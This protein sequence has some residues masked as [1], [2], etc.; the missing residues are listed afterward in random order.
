MDN[1]HVKGAN[2][3]A[4][5][6]YDGTTITAGVGT[7]LSIVGVN[8]TAV[9]GPNLTNATDIGVANVGTNVT[10]SIQNNAVTDA[11]FRQ[12]A[13]Y[14]VV[15]KSTT[16]TG[17]VA[18]IGP[19]S[20]DSV[21]G[22]VGAG[23][24]G[25]SK[26]TTNQISS[27][28]ATAGMV[29]GFDGSVV[30]WT[31]LPAAGTSF[32]VGST[33][34]SNPSFSGTTPAA[35]T[36]GKNIGFQTSGT[37]VSAAL[38]GDGNAAHYFDG[39]GG[40]STPAGGSAVAVNGV[41]PSSPQNI[42]NTARM[43]WGVTGTNILSY[44][45]NLTDAEIASSG[46]TTRSKLPT[47]IAYEDEN[48]VFSLSNHFNGPIKLTGAQNWGWTDLGSSTNVTGAT[49]SLFKLL[50]ANL[51]I[52][53][54]LND[55]ESVRLRFRQDGT[56]SRT[57]A[58][59]GIHVWTDLT[60]QAGG[61][62]PSLDTNA[63][64]VTIVDLW[65][66]S[67]T[68]FGMVYAAPTPFSYRLNNLSSS[69]GQLIGFNTNDS[70]PTV[71]TMGPNTIIS[72]GVLYAYGSA[73][74]SVDDTAFASSWNGV[75]TTAP[76]KNAV[77][78]WGHI[79]DTD[80]DGK[81]N[82]LDS[83]SAAGFPY[84]DASGVIQGTRVIVGNA[85]GVIDVASGDGASGNTTLTWTPAKTHNTTWSDGTDASITNYWN[86]AG[87]DV[88][89]II[90]SNLY[91]FR[92]PVRVS[93][94]SPSL[95]VFT[96]SNTNLSSTGTI[97][98]SSANI[99]LKQTKYLQL[100]RPDYGDGA[101]AIPQTNSYTASGLMHFTMSGSADTNANFIIYEFT[102]PADIDTAVA[103]TATFSWVSGGTDTDDYSFDLS[104]GLGVAGAAWP[105]TIT[106][107]YTRITTTP[108][109][110]AS[111]DLQKSAATTLTGWAASM[112]AGTPISVKLARV[113]N[114]QDDTA[115]DVSLVIAY[116]STQ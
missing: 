27:T 8:G 32:Y 33:N 69:G 81:V 116:G 56:G 55:G 66:E 60:N 13:G 112:T 75:T 73:S 25:F 102:V 7:N 44:A 113:N 71:I 24:L 54:S 18:D 70:S 12:G 51:I 3:G 38:V 29:I 93:S 111:G 72:N 6:S 47:P 49:N 50:S 53:N 91:E 107:G 84:T 57:L 11:K 104:Y 39:T 41:I 83:I 52:T 1:K 10:F 26:V 42:T 15:G 35:P 45:T 34:V 95:P 40:F 114:S 68:N 109:T 103:M 59:D 94:I 19:A 79:G 64:R 80:D 98:A 21:F 87:T 17:N 97:D 48:N 105:P 5:L 99:T 62:M 88:T 28:N 20:N 16:G 100:V 30:G 67:T 115:R 37:N 9:N 2:I 85:D 86:L 43:V 92:N 4:G 58:I 108:T 106:S 90:G 31:N 63:G 82:V 96:D 46:I 14:T 76:S 110:P 89:N 78:D 23:N 74:G 36:N 65:K 61:T 77:Y 22:K 101:G